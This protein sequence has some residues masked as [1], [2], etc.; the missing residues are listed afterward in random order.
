MTIRRLKTGCDLF[1]GRTRMKTENKVCPRC[2]QTYT[3]PPAV[4]RNG[5]GDIC[6]SCGRIE[7]FE[8][9]GFSP[10]TIKELSEEIDRKEEMVRKK[11]EAY[12][13]G[14]I[15]EDEL[16]TKEENNHTD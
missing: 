1:A 3:E 15:G 10:E 12:N 4:S 2:G 9:V 8:A 5:L 7:A 13:A 16:F 6:P 11:V 14:E